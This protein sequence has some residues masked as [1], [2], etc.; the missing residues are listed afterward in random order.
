VLDRPLD[1][2]AVDRLHT[3]SE[4]NPLFLIEALRADPDRPGADS[5]SETTRPA[6]IS[7]AVT[8]TPETTL[9]RKSSAVSTS[10]ARRCLSGWSS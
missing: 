9:V 10:I 5:G 1:D 2:T 3:D 6:S 8:Q 4:G 7:W